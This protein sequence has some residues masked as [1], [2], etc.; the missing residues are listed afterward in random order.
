[1]AMLSIDIHVTFWFEHDADDALLG[2]KRSFYDLP[3]DIGVFEDDHSTLNND[4]LVKFILTKLSKD[5]AK[6]IQTIDCYLRKAKMVIR[7]SK[8]YEVL[9]FPTESTKSREEW[10]KYVDQTLNTRRKRKQPVRL[11]DEPATKRTRK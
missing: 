6:E 5:E 10:R 9:S 7:R 8:K 3:F 1:M 4:A 2:M 11:I